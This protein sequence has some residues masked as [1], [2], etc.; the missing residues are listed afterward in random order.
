[1][2]DIGDLDIT[3]FYIGETA[4]DFE[5]AQHVKIDKGNLNAEF[6][7]HAQLFAYYATAYE[8]ALDVEVSHKAYLD[9]VYAVEDHKARMNAEQV[10]KK[11]TEK[12]VENTV[13][14]SQNYTDALKA[15]LTAKKQTGI[16]KAVKDALI[17]KRSMLISLGANFRAEGSS[18]VS[19]NQ[20]LTESKK[21][22]KQMVG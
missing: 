19:L 15:Y 8:L 13:I 16:I 3:Q 1:M 18:D 17:E 11:L 14:T 5:A 21:V 7:N 6:E 22:L 10:N 2:S 20:K 9:R 4:Y 12:M